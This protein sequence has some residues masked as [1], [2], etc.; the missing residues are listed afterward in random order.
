M[1]TRRSPSPNASVLRATSGGTAASAHAGGSA[2]GRLA[3]E[4]S[5]DA[6]VRRVM[7]SLPPSAQASGSV[8]VGGG[9]RPAS[10]PRIHDVNSPVKPN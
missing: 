7:P 5:L 4:D 6:E 8:V 9:S 1:A 3:G 2:A 10:G